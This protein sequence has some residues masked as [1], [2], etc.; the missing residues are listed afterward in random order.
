MIVRH[1]FLP[2]LARRRRLGGAPA[3]RAARRGFTLPELIVAIL[4]LTVGILGLAGTSAVITRQMGSGKRTTVAA[5]I[6]Q[7]RLDSL[8][9]IDCTLAASG[10]AS[11]RGV[12]EHWI[13]ADGNDVKFITDTVRVLGLARPIIYQSIIPCRD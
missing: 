7:A 12:S 5:T 8:A 4:I 13:V 3:P 11:T 6:V 2:R 10:T 1:A 9:A